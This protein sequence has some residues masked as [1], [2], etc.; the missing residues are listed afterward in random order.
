VEKP[1]NHS[2]VQTFL[3]GAIVFGVFSASRLAIQFGLEAFIISGDASDFS[4]LIISLSTVFSSLAGILTLRLVIRTIGIPSKEIWGTPSFHIKEIGKWLFLC[5]VT[6]CLYDAIRYAECREIVPEWLV[7]IYLT[8]HSWVLFLLSFVGVAPV[9]EEL[10]FRGFL[11][12]RLSK[13]AL[14]V[15][16]A[17]VV[18]SL[19]WALTHMQYTFFDM[20]VIFMLGMFFCYARIKTA[21]VYTCVFMHMVLNLWTFLEIILLSS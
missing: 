14:G 5:I 18:T 9:F 20:T 7:S 1:D 21:S 19:L 16:G 4:G 15:F 10:F 11:V 2:L 3:Y 13:S 8:T 17:S 6:A 12:N